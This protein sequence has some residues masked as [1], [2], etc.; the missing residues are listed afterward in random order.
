M[1]LFGKFS[2]KSLTLQ[3]RI[4]MAPLT[5]CRAAQD[6]VP[7]PYAAEYYAQR[8]SAGLMISE[9]TCI[10]AQAKG[11]A[12]TPGIY[13]DAQISNWQKITENVH[14]HGGKIFCQLWHVGRI[15]HPSLQEDNALPVAPSAICPEGEA[16][17]ETGPQ[18]FVT[19]RALETDEIPGIIEQ[20]VHAAIAAKKAGFDGIELHAANGYLLDQFMRSGS[21]LRQDQ[22]GG[23]IEN[24]IRLTLEVI[25]ALLKI[26][27]KD[28]IGIRLSPVASYHS[29]HDDNPM[30]TFMA[31]ILALNKRDILYIHCV[32]ASERAHRPNQETFDFLK[33][34]LAFNGL[35][36]ANNCYTKT[37]AISAL[38]HHDADLICFGRPFI[39]NPDLVE[40]LRHDYPLTEAPMNTWYGGGAQGYIDW[41]CH[42]RQLVDKI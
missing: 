8:A 13:T 36:I 30:A 20:Y 38:E 10:S 32:E 23:T 29:M 5:R 28:C 14:A 6:G 42:L 24:R 37:L 27:P 1:D 17:T 18:N 19:P 2:H 21:N 12:F 40:R 16:F 11:Y 4:V 35:Y 34:R 3:N 22:Y 33:L 7:S 41:P 25:D 39:G 31:L 9:A 26:W 15:S